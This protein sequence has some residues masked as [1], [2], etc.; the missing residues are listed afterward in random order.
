MNTKIH[1]LIALAAMF[2]APA[3]KESRADAPASEKEEKTSTEKPT[4]KAEKEAGRR[5]DQD[6]LDQAH[7]GE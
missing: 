6:R 4:E 7:A 2:V 5:A 1:T 3:C